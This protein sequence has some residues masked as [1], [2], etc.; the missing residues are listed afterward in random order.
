MAHVFAHVFLFGVCV[1]FF[2][3][4]MSRWYLPTG[5]RRINSRTTVKNRTKTAS[6]KSSLLRHTELFVILR[7]TNAQPFSPRSIF[8]ACAFTPKSMHVRHELSLERWVLVCPCNFCSPQWH[9][10][11]FVNLNYL[12]AL[13]T[14]H[15]CV[16]KMDSDTRNMNGGK[17][18]V[19]S[20]RLKRL[21]P[22]I[23]V[24][25]C[26]SSIYPFNIRENQS[27]GR[28]CIRVRACDDCS[29]RQRT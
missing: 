5:H 24:W 4:Q 18:T 27:L 19:A 8:F 7:G 29:G 15:K 16:N 3:C 28:V 26:R 25:H 23:C 17:V 21:R 9:C 13:Q 6:D 11:L 10:S 1:C 12:V 14:W 22:R 20:S 2:P